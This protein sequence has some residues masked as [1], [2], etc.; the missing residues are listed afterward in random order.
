MA[1]KTVRVKIPRGNADDMIDL[2]K[3]VLKH[4]KELGK[5]SLLD[6]V[7]VTALT[8]LLK[9]AEPERE[10]AK[11]LEA[12]AQGFNQSAKN[13]LGISREQNINTPNTGLY[14]ITQVRDTLLKKLKGVE[15]KLGEYGFNVAIGSAKGRSKK[16]K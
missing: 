5:N 16:T 14:H 6:K 12:A 15:E 11:E 3:H 9:A 10:K 13:H 8:A 2:I 4:D 1:R 7:D